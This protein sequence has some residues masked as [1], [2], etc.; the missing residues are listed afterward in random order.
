VAKLSIRRLCIFTAR[1]LKGVRYTNQLDLDASYHGNDGSSVNV[2]SIQYTVGFLDLL[3][4]KWGHDTTYIFPVSD[5]ILTSSG[6][7]KSGLYSRLQARVPAI[8]FL[9][10]SS[11]NFAARI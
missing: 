10:S 3:E 8:R 11:L 6:G 4:P 7:I 1:M 2:E 5:S 9:A